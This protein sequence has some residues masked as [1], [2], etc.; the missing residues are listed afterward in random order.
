MAKSPSTLVDPY[1]IPSL[2]NVTFT[3]II[4]SGELFPD[5]TYFG[6]IPD[7]IGA[8]DNG[9]GTIT[10]LVNHELRAG[11]GLVRDHGSRGA[12]VDRLVIDA[13]TLAVVAS[14]DLIKTV[15]LWDVA[16]GSYF[17]TTTAFDRL[18]SS[19]LPVQTAFFNSGSG[20]G[21]T[22]LIYLTGEERD[23]EGRPFAT[24]VTGP[25]AGT[26]FELP[27][28]GN[29]AFE[30]VVANPHAQDKT[31]VAISDDVDGGQ[32]YIY[33]GQKQSSG[34]EIDKAGLT[35]GVLYGLKVSGFSDETD[36]TP[37]EGTFTLQ[38]TGPGGDVS[39]MTGAEIEAESDLEGV[40][41]FLRPED[42]C[43][44]PDNP[45]VLYFTTTN[46]FFDGNS[47]LYKATFTDIGNPELGGTIEAVLTGSEGHKRL[48]NLTI[49][50]GKIILQEDPGDV[51]YL[52]KI[53]E[54]DI[55]TDSLTQLAEFDPARFEPT[56]P[57]FITRDE[58]SSGVLDVSAWFGDSD[59][60][61]FLVNAMIDVTTGGTVKRGQLM[62]MYVD[63]PAAAELDS[64]SAAIALGRLG[65]PDSNTFGAFQA[66]GLQSPLAM[67]DFLSRADDY[68][69]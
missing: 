60:R 9:D 63:D 47:R 30:N 44:D 57:G 39:S 49:S 29:L 68:W 18:C 55:A 28:L 6:G 7:G 8:F 66:L 3:S 32:V 64:S 43:W 25:N 62:I 34:L 13:D 24:I 26:A 37:A 31:I 40:T 41:A 12:F 51:D 67:F 22:E 5:G 20:L 16:T 11:A 38:E 10:V 27:F 2:D 50:N 52:A 14:D 35:N 58:E 61:A 23:F 42:I 33:V 59:T 54:Y 21:T 65:L 36:A 69:L 45:N 56:S 53:W 17:S 1:L 19:D 15:Q 4:A 46:T 48:D